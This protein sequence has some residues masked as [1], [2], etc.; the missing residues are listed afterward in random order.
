L[1]GVIPDSYALTY[2]LLQVKDLY[3]EAGVLGF[4]KGVLPTL[5]MVV[6]S[7]PCQRILHITECKCNLIADC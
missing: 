4:W 6:F 5:I 1:I 2:T 3:K 7:F